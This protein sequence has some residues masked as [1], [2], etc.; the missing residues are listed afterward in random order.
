LHGY[1]TDAIV[2]DADKAG[3]AAACET[4]RSE[5]RTITKHIS[6]T[7]AVEPHGSTRVE[8]ELRRTYQTIYNCRVYAYCQK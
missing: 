7:S 8:S 1:N 6:Q 2:E 5:D 3:I 4:D